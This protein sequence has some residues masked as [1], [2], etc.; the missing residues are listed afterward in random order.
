MCVEVTN[1]YAIEALLD[2]PHGR[3]M[4]A[5]LCRKLLSPEVV[6]ILTNDEKQILRVTLEECSAE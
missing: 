6:H 3:A 5:D 1:E 4:V 2:T